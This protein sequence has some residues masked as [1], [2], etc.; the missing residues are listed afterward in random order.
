MNAVQL[1]G[2]LTS[3]PELRFIA[4][5]GQAVATFTLAVDKNLSKEKKQQFEQ[6]NKPTADFIR[7]VCWGKM[8]ESVANH[9]VKGRKIAV[10]GSI[11]TST[12]K[13]DTGETRYYTDVVASNIEFL[14]W[15]DK[16]QSQSK[17]AAFDDDFANNFRAVEDDEDIP[18]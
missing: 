2:R 10:Q 9:Q 5:S 18:F 16:P 12:S 17:P 15:G 8:G 4:G 7:V 11:S 6:Q 14:E 3:D 1:I 13:T